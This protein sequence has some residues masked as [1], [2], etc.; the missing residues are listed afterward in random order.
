MTGVKLTGECNFRGLPKVLRTLY[1]VLH[2]EIV[3][4]L[5]LTPRL[6]F[7]PAT[8]DGVVRNGGEEGIAIKSESPPMVTRLNTN[9]MGW[10]LGFEPT[11]FVGLVSF[12]LGHAHVYF[13]RVNDD[14]VV[15]TVG[16]ESLE[17]YADE[18]ERVAT[19]VA[20]F[21]QKVQVR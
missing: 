9:N 10:L 13:M 3:D 18:R 21:L 7:V 11:Q 14:N 16:Y 12:V 8:A 4:T 19:A 20:R 5:E 15:V 2:P 1:R 6:A 17:A